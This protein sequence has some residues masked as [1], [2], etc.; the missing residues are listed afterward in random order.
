MIVS[1]R[2]WLINDLISFARERTTCVHPGH[3]FPLGEG[4]YRL[5]GSI[6]QFPLFGG[7]GFIQRA[8]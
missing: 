6:R 7:T 5:C 4:V 8:L 1:Q 2:Q 3:L